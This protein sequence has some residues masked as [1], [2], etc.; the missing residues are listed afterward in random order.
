MTSSPYSFEPPRVHQLLA[1]LGR[2]TQQFKAWL[3]TEPQIDLMDQISIDN[4][5][6]V[7]YICYGT[8]KT[9]YGISWKDRPRG[10]NN[11]SS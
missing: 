9:K 10:D 5:L 6:A 8:W 11:P 7:L 3:D 4:H 1:D 2:V